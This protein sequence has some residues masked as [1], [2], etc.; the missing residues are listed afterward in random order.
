MPGGVWSAVRRAECNRIAPSWR[1][2]VDKIVRLLESVKDYVNSLPPR[3][4]RK[5]V[6]DVEETLDDEDEDEFEED[7]EGAEDEEEDEEAEEEFEP[8]PRTKTRKGVVESMFGLPDFRPKV[9]EEE[10]QPA[11]LDGLLRG[12]VRTAKEKKAKR[13]TGV[14]F[15]DSLEE[16]VEEKKPR[17]RAPEKKAPKSKLK[18]VLGEWRPEPG[19]GEYGG[20]KST[21]GD[22]KSVV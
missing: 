2:S 5:N 10:E 17:K 6:D 19:Y 22:R 16:E 7:E 3:I 21:K 12:F 13:E 4:R 1:S 20:R 8:R 18:S 15:D 9:V 11:W 14:K